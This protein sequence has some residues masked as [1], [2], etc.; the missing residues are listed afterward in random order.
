MEN[1]PLISILIPCFNS[2]KTIDATIQSALNQNY[3]NLEIIIND[4]CSSDGTYSYLLK[5]YNGDSR[6]KIHQNHVNIGMCNNWNLLFKK[7]TGSY[8]L[9]LDADDL[10]D[11]SFLEQTIKIAI[12]TQADFVGSSYQFLDVKQKEYSKVFTHINRKSG[13]LIYPLED[14]FINYPFH[15]CFTLLKAD[16]VKRISPS[17]YFMDT[18]VGDAEFQIRAALAPNFKAYFLAEE[19]GSYCFHGANSS[20]TPLKQAKSFLF[21]VVSEHHSKLL[22]NMGKAYRKKMRAN[23]KLYLKEMLLGRTPWHYQLLKSSFTFA[24]L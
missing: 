13:F 9:K 3:Q 21:D 4:D 16:F 2:I 5:Q 20:L 17:Y 19:L 7:A 10:I 11:T 18:E 14:I 15:L 24:W 8:W 23:F 1:Q 6:I 12:E 22:K